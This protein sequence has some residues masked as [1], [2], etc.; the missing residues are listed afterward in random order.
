MPVKS[1]LTVHLSGCRTLVATEAPCLIPKISSGHPKRYRITGWQ[2]VL[3]IMGSGLEQIILTRSFS[4]AFLN[5][6]QAGLVQHRP[7]LQF[8]C[9]VAG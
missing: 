3:A 2:L 5:I 7:R 6:L 4:P 9:K 8:L 1:L